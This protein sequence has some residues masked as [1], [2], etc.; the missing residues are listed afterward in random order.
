MV[1]KGQCGSKHLPGERC[2]DPAGLGAAVSPDGRLEQ[3]EGWRVPSAGSGF[4]F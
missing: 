2:R 3:R 1:C 4:A